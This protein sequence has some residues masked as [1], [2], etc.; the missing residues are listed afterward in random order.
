MTRNGTT[1][2]TTI[3][4]HHLVAAVRRAAARFACLPATAAVLAAAADALEGATAVEATLAAAMAATPGTAEA[5]ALTDAVVDTARRVATTETIRAAQRAI[6]DA[7]LHTAHH[8]P[9]TCPRCRPDHTG[10]RRQLLI[11]HGTKCHG[12][13]YDATVGA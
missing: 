2:T 11:N 6:D 12:C 4:D 1:T 3:P 10:A 8:A 13:G 7:K 9:A 5:D